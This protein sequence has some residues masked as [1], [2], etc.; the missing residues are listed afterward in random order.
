[1]LVC[2]MHTHML[3]CVEEHDEEEYLGMFVFML[4]WY[5][6]KDNF[7]CHSSGALHLIDRGR[8]LTA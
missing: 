1:M 6:P 4:P 7:K 3:V 2:S 5:T 8:S